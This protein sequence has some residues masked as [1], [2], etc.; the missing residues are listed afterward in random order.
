[1]KKIYP[2]LTHDRTANTYVCN[3]DKNRHGRTK[4]TSVAVRLVQWSLL[5][6]R[7]KGHHTYDALI[8]SAAFSATPYK[9]ADIWALICNG[10]IEASTT[11]TFAVS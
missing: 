4:C 10:M 5:V 3:Q 9:V 2:D 1:M 8:K 6:R 7:T 11:R